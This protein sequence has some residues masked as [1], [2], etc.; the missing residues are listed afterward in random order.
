LKTSTALLRR[1]RPVLGTYVEI[2]VFLDSTDAAIAAVEQAFEAMLDVQRR[3]AFHCPLSDV[4]RIN[5]AQAGETVPVHPWTAEVLD[6]A[7]ELCVASDGRFDCCTGGRGGSVLDVELLDDG[8]VMVH[9]PV[10][11][12]LGG[13]ATGFAVDRAV[14]ALSAGGIGSA[15]VNA[16]GDLRV[17]GHLPH[18]LHVRWPRASSAAVVYLGD[19][20]NGAAATAALPLSAGLASGLASGLVSGPASGQFGGYAKAR[21]GWTGSGAGG[22]E[23]HAASRGLTVLA[24]LCAVAKGLSAALGMGEISGGGFLGR[25]DARAILV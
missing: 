4:A 12:N 18:A 17:L 19:L 2:A 13:I 16:G 24:P 5:S 15:M 9:R 8:A 7:H 14:D 22:E 25:F 1:S 20:A 11:L 23:G 21:A 3:L 6:L 10:R